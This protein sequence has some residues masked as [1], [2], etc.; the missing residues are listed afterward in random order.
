MTNALLSSKFYRF[1]FC[2]NFSDTTF[3]F[4]KDPK[5]ELDTNIVI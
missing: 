4:L 5:G 2:L 1:P 3:S